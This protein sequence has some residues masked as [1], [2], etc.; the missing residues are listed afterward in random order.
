[1]AAWHHAHLSYQAQ[2]KQKRSHQRKRHTWLDGAAGLL[3][4]DFETLKR[5]VFENL[6]AV[7]RASSLVEMVNALIR[8]SLHTCKG[9]ITQETFNL[10]MF[11]HNHRRDKSGKRTGQAPLT[12]GRAGPGHAL[13]FC[14]MQAHARART[15]LVRTT[16]RSARHRQDAVERLHGC[17][18]CQIMAHHQEITAVGTGQ[19]FRLIHHALLGIESF[20]C[21]QN[22][23]IPL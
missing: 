20:E 17:M 21:D 8:P 9:H 11:Y 15:G 12:I 1:M 13:R 3:E 18:P 7:G 5:L 10:I 16:P 6:D 23:W 4:H 19:E 14:C 2:A 22:L